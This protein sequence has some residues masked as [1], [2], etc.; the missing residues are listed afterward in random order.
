MTGHGEMQ[1]R[2]PA[3]GGAFNHDGCMDLFVGNESGVA[4]GWGS[5]PS[6]LYLSNCD[7]TVTEVS[8]RVGIEV[9]AVVKGSAWGDVNN[10]GLP[11]L[12][13]SVYG[14]PNRLYM[15]RGGKSIDTWRFEEVAARAGVQLPNM[16][17]PTWVWDYDN[18][19]WE[20]LLVER[21][22]GVVAQHEEAFP[23]LVVVGPEPGWG[24]HV[25]QL[26]SRPCRYPPEAP[27]VD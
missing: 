19:G 26:H 22:A 18:D 9:D 24:R 23:A 17:F 6:E 8:H 14:A 11:D 1:H 12:F 15:N 16:S 21:H 2:D 7:G 27:P 5:H 4:M 25:R 13:V 20:D 3:A 10:D